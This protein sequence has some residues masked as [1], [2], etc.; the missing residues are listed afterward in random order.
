MSNRTLAIK[1]YL[2]HLA[3]LVVYIALLPTL[4]ILTFAAGLFGF[5]MGVIL[6]A[7]AVT[8]H[9]DARNRY[10]PAD[11]KRKIE[12]PRY[13]PNTTPSV[14]YPMMNQDRRSNPGW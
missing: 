5:G 12:P 9:G 4:A 6:Y 13:I 10:Q 8:C 3:F 1:R 2:T 14:I 11:K 7:T